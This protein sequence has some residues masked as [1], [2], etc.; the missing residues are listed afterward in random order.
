[1]RSTERV[2]VL[3]CD[4]RPLRVIPWEDAIGHILAGT[5]DL[6]EQYAGKFIRTVSASHP[7]PAVLRLRDFVAVKP[8]MRFNRLNVLA[9]DNYTCCYCGEAPKTKVGKPKLEDLT[10]DHVI[11]RAQSRNGQVRTAD[12]DLIGVTCWLNIVACCGGPGG[13]N[14]RKGDRTPEQAGMKL[15][16]QPR[17][18]ASLDVLRM[19]LRRVK[20]PGEWRDYLPPGAEAWGGYWTD[21]L[22]ED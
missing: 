14:E 19:S 21:Q 10:L 8:R 15:L 20:I 1:M 2:L 17:V 16:R 18:P 5:A 7:W 4:Y 13:C 9:R 11:P 6:I 3:N 12:G 22:D